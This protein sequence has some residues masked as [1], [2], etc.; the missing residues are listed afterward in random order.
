M[1]LRRP[2]VLA[3]VVAAGTFTG[4]ALAY[5]CHPNVAGTRMLSVRGSVVSLKAHGA[6][7]DLVLKRG[8]G[9]CAQLSW[10]VSTGASKTLGLGCPAPARLQ[11]S[12]LPP[13]LTAGAAGQRVVVVRGAGASPDLLR[14][15]AGRRLLRTLPLPARPET[16]QSSGGIAVFAAAGAGVYAVRLSDGLFG[17]LGPNGGSFAPRLDARGVLF[18]DGESKAALRDGTTV[19][20]FVPRAGIEKIIAR[21]ARPLVTGGPIRAISMDGPRVALAVG[22]SQGRC[23]RVLYWNVAWWPVQRVSSPSGVT[24]NVRPNGVEIR[25]VAIGGFR[26]EWLTTQNGT[27]RLVAGSPLCQEWVLGRFQ[28]ASQVRALAGDGQTLAFAWNAGGRTTVSRVNGHYRPVTV[29]VGAGMPRIAVDGARVAVL[30][31][32]GK[33]TIGKR[34]F[35]IGKARAI[36]LQGSELAVLAGERLGVYSAVTGKRLHSW[37]VP[38]TARGIDLQDGVVA[39]A[40]GRTA[41]VLDTATGRSAV[42][43]H[44]PTRVTGV[45]IEGPGLAYA[46]S[47]GSK[48]VARF[49]TTRTIDVALG[50]LAA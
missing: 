41:V 45:Q 12:T 38:L 22:D 8:A 27:A 6:G 18:H 49:L 36:A 19:L 2:I 40:N 15:Y 46:W 11:A 21:T 3:S 23:D 17:Y 14:V 34:S 16:L 30:W 32:T 33:V 48:G 25:S 20:E 50:R 28:R 5:V 26:A 42:V 47:S 7:F 4:A 9:H 43:A 31:P 10:N 13:A 37:P 24:C 1:S 29:A 39:F 44:G 35:D